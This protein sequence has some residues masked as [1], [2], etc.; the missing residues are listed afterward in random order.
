MMSEWVLP[1]YVAL[2]M[3]QLFV[4]LLVAT[5]P[6]TASEEKIGARLALTCWAWPV[7]LVIALV[8]GFLRLWGKAEWGRR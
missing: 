2:T 3:V 1:A 4:G 5:W 6:G 7:V 8:K